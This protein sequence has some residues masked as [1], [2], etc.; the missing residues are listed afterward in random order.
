MPAPPAG[1]DPFPKPAPRGKRHVDAARLR[2]IASMPG[3]PWHDP[4]LW[5][6]EQLRCHREAA[7]RIALGAD[8]TTAPSMRFDNPAFAEQRRHPHHRA[9]REYIPPGD[10]RFYRTTAGRVSY[11]PIVVSN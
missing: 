3:V 8:Q 7:A 5:D 11:R 9:Y 10:L 6:A 1:P 2:F 4:R